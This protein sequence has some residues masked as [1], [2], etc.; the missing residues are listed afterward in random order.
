MNDNGEWLRQMA[1]LQ[2]Q[3]WRGWQSMAGQAIAQQAPRTPWQEGLDLWT[4][5]FAMGGA[6]AAGGLGGDDVGA[7][8]LGY[9]RQY[10]EMLQ[11]MAGQGA[12]GGGALDP[13]A[14]VKEMRA[15]H[16]RLGRG[17][18][19]AGPGAIPWFGGVDAAQ[20]EQMVKA[21]TAAPMRGMQNE[22]RGLFDLPTFGLSREHQ[23]R[24]Q[25]LAKAWIDYQSATSRYNEL[26]LKTAT[27]TFDMLENRLAEREQPGRQIESVRGIYDLWIDAAEDAFAEVAMSPEY[28]AVYGELVN[29][30]MRVRAGINTELEHFAAQFGMPTRTEVDSMARQL[31]ELRRELRRLKAG[32]GSAAKDGAKAAPRENAPGAASGQGEA[33]RPRVQRAKTKRARESNA[34]APTT[35]AKASARA[36][37]SSEQGARKQATRASA[38]KTPAERDDS[39]PMIQSTARKNAGAR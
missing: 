8:L 3:Y 10:L 38:R 22:V 36:K 21:F 5:P 23:E 25:A 30:Q 37:A 1:D 31:H 11:Q 27:R 9:G 33:T 26:M 7:R 4:R 13:Q 12:A 24:T 32:R 14:W 15:A 16:E 2:Q 28:R 29:S 34:A 35:A 39:A 20:I 17:V 6:P 18:M 19:N